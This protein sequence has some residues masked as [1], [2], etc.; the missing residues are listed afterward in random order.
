MSCS[1]A[2]CHHHILCLAGLFHRNQ[3]HHLLG[4][5]LLGWWGRL[6]RW[7]GCLLRW[8]GR[9]L[10][11]CRWRWGRGRCCLGKLGQEQGSQLREHRMELRRWNRVSNG[12]RGQGVLFGMTI[13]MTIG[14]TTGMTTAACHQSY[15][16]RLQQVTR[17]PIC[18][19]VVC[20]NAHTCAS[21]APSLVPCCSLWWSCVVMPC[22]VRVG[23]TLLCAPTYP[24]HRLQLGL[25]CWRRRWRFSR[26]RLS[27][28]R[29]WG[30]RLGRRCLCW[31]RLSLQSV[32]NHAKLEFSKGDER[33]LTRVPVRFPQ[34][35]GERGRRFCLLQHDGAW[36]S[37]HQATGLP[38][39]V[40]G[41]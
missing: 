10:R 36:R 3:H 11:W 34:V 31:R 21:P 25:L 17:L 22:C 39:A 14:M 26:W 38:L 28:R 40:M 37:G 16:L 5:L 8:W 24:T 20:I 32:A 9:L 35:L 13:G 12:Y 41:H 23:R 1:P 27:R 29:F 19:I 2:S 15:I 33:G 4:C 30:W 7:W 18:G 6:L